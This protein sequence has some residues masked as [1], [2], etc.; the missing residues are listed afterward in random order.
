MA[1][2]I[3]GTPKP[4]FFDSNGDPLVSGTLSILDPDT[5]TNKASYPTLAD[6][7]AGTNPNDNPLTLDSRGEPSTSLFGLD[8]NSYKVVLKDSAGGTVWT[9]AKVTLPDPA[10]GLTSVAKSVGTVA[11]RVNGTTPDYTDTTV[12]FTR[13]AA[14]VESFTLAANASASAGNNNSVLAALIGILQ[15]KG[16][17]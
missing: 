9:V 14:V 10:S 8:R 12:A 4:A 17:I 15:G 11:L 7:D 2:P 5:D 3:L 16:V 6:A 13:S 1:F